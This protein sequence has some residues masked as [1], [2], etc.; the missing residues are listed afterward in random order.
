MVAVTYS[1]DLTVTVTGLVVV[2]QVVIL[3][4]SVRMLVVIEAGLSDVLVDVVVR[5]GGG[6]GEAAI[7]GRTNRELSKRIA[8][9]HR[10]VCRMPIFMGSVILRGGI[11]HFP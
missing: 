5:S 8:H 7:A 1:I 10:G 11:S 6:L 2:S 9:S 3:I 4:V